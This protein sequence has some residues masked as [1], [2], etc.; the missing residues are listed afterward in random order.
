M[1]LRQALAVTLSVLL[2]SCSSSMLPSGPRLR[3]QEDV[4]T[5]Q[6]GVQSVSPFED[7]ISSLEPQFELKPQ[8]AFDRAIAQT[9]VEDSALVNQFLATLQVALPQ[10]THT[11]TA[12]SANDGTKTTD[13]STDSHSTTPPAAVTASAPGTVT[14]LGSVT[15]PATAVVDVDAALRYRAATALAQEVSLLNHYVRDA[16]VRTGTKPYIVRLLLTVMPGARNEP[17]DAYSTISFFTAKSQPAPIRSSL[18]D[19]LHAYKTT[20]YTVKKDGHDESQLRA[21]RTTPEEVTDALIEAQKKECGANTSIPVDVI[22]LLVTDELE[23]NLHTN[24]LQRIRDI[25]AALQGTLSNIGVGVG[26]RYHSEELDKTLNR[27][28]NSIYALGQPSPNAVVARLGAAYA[29]SKYV[30]VPRSYGVTLL[31]LAKTVAAVDSADRA[32]NE[33]ILCPAITFSASTQMHD[34]NAR[35][36]MPPRPALE[37][38]RELKGLLESRGVAMTDGDMEKMLKAAGSGTFDDVKSLTDATAA[39]SDSVWVSQRSGHSAGNFVVSLPRVSLPSDKDHFS[40]IDDGTATTLAINHAAN[41]LPDRLHANIAAQFADDWIFLA[42]TDVRVGSYGRS[43]TFTFPSLNKVL[44]SRAEKAAAE[45]KAAAAKKEPRSKSDTQDKKDKIKTVATPLHIYGE[46]IYGRSLTS[47]SAGTDRNAPELLWYPMLPEGDLGDQLVQ[48]ATKANVIRPGE[49]PISY[50]LTKK[51][52]KTPSEAGFKISV[53]AAVI[54]D[55]DGA[56]Q[57]LVEIRN[58]DPEKK[59]EAHLQIAEG[60]FIDK[61]SEPPRDGADHVGGEG[62]WLLSL[63]G[64]RPGTPIVLHAF[65]LDEKKEQVAAEDVHVQVVAKTPKPDGKT[66]EKQE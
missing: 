32:G 58:T 62:A 21:E 10:I 7:Y 46:V 22:P 23:S 26:T 5:V 24:A 15:L 59:R 45:E 30:T 39:W 65:R 25:A 38:K 9:Q 31:V 44:A 53:P 37:S 3:T 49:A 52:D 17:Y 12:S 8:D 43:A 34:T 48:D 36:F 40:L 41:L 61:T 47:W 66:K 19:G 51:A 33:A 50:V 20:R 42:N 64:L 56:G 57:M 6:V 63:H 60:A 35:G 1:M 28:L 55:I 2:V 16:A 54:A 29:S 13:T 11:K 14:P 18:Y 27:N 4:G